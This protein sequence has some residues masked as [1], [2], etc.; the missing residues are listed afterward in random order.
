M[1]PENEVNDNFYDK[2]GDDDAPL[3]INALDRGDNG[4][5]PKMDRLQSIYSLDS[6][7]KVA[8]PERGFMTFLNGLI[9][10]G[11]LALPHAVSKIGVLPALVLFLV[12][13]YLN[14]HT[15]RL[16][17]IVASD[18]R[19]VKVDFGRLA[20]R[21]IYR[22]WVRYFV[23]VNLY[24]MQFG[25][26]ITGLVFI[27]QYFDKIFCILGAQTLCEHE[28]LRFLLILAFVLPIGAIT[29]IKY[30]AIPNGLGIFF[31]FAFLALFL[32]VT[33]NSIAEN[34]F[35]Y[36][37][38]KEALTVFN[39]ESLPLAF[40]TILYAYEGIGL[41]MDVRTAVSDHGS[42]NKVLFWTFVISTT[43]YTSVGIM[44]ALAFGEGAKAVIFLNLDQTNNLIV[45][46]EFGYL[47]A[48]SIMIPTILFPVS[49]IIENWKIFRRITE[50]RGSKKKSF[51]GRQL[52]RQ[53]I[54]LGL[55]LIAAI[56]PSFDLFLSFLGG[57]NFAILSFVIPVV[58]YNTRFKDDSSKRKIRI[59]N[60]MI[61]VPGIVLGLVASA[62]SL[63]KM[64]NYKGE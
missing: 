60:W 1:F 7:V 48:L 10:G 42:F 19:L 30:L 3:S 35:A 33:S 53:P 54:V 24:I 11:M 58:L 62:E 38:F 61:M 5:S 20:E 37:N 13:G 2:L 43:G 21:V 15:M 44:G 32:T 45:F 63:V 59:F 41:V 55:C 4:S 39:P 16:L 6:S 31:Q 26:A 34:G 52:I 50:D 17:H 27:N 18:L 23:E 28:Y 56:I 47:I 25:T 49:R 9:G 40:A 22:R 64:V 12:I 8:S 14:L 46:V 29:N 36:E 57:F 51:L